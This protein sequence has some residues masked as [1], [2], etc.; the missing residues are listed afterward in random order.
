MR[1]A[2]IV[3]MAIPVFNLFWW[4]GKRIAQRV[5]ARRAGKAVPPISAGAVADGFARAA[6]AALPAVRNDKVRDGIERGIDILDRIDL[7]DTPTERPKAKKERG[8]R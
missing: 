3:P 7:G 8:L 5:R 4:A 1:A 2:E 6:N